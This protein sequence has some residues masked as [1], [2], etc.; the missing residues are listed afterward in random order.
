M[1]HLLGSNLTGKMPFS[2]TDWARKGQLPT[3]LEPKDILDAMRNFRRSGTQ[4]GALTPE[5]RTN[6]ERLPDALKTTI[7]HLFV[8]EVVAERSVDRILPSIDRA[9]Y[10]QG[11]GTWREN[12]ADVALGRRVESTESARK[13][14]RQ[15]LAEGSLDLMEGVS[16]ALREWGEWTSSNTVGGLRFPPIQIPTDLGLVWITDSSHAN[17][18]LGAALVFDLGGDDEYSTPDPLPST[19]APLVQL[20]IDMDGND[21]YRDE[22]GGYLACGIGGISAIYDEKGKD[23]FRTAGMGLGCGILGVGWVVDLLGDDTIIATG[24]HAVGAGLIGVGSFYKFG[25]NNQF[26]SQGQAFGFGGPYGVG[27]FCSAGGT[28]TYDLKG[29]HCLGANSGGAGIGVACDASGDDKYTVGKSSMG[30]GET[31]GFGFFWDGFGSDIYRVGERCLGSG[32]SGGFGLAAEAQGND[33]YTSVEGLGYARSGTGVFLELGGD[34]R[35]ESSY[36]LGYSLQSGVSFCWDRAG[37]DTYNLLRDL[38]G[39]ATAGVPNPLPLSQLDSVALFLDSA[40]GDTYERPEIGDGTN[41]TVG[42]A[43]GFGCDI[44]K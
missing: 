4:V 22:V 18:P 34:D 26:V 25:G 13:L 16:M 41:W 28:D 15:A 19:A 2:E 8:S 27:V 29:P 23:E 7:W 36:G 3:K 44:R 33:Q 39:F 30:S 20:I 40:G 38:P 24:P 5:S 37:T 21:R 43:L 10:G 1:L 32:I 42:D 12:W 31:G 35:Y 14:D 17:I 11:R 9:R 6:W